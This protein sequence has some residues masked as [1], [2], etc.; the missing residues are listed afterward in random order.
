MAAGNQARVQSFKIKFSGVTIL[1]GVDSFD[2]TTFRS[3]QTIV[4]VA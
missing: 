3:H 1:Q 2:L 4:G